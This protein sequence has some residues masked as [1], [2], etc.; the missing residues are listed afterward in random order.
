MSPCFWRAVITTKITS[1]ASRYWE[2]V[3]QRVPSRFTF[4]YHHHIL[5][6]NNI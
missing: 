6:F 5:L 3:S 2:P 4:A 1:G